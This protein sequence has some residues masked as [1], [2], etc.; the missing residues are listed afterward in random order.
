M[1]PTG[2]NSARERVLAVAERLFAERGYAAV[3]LRDI[4]AEVGLKHA[5][6]YH[7]VPGGKEALFIEVTERS[8]A[9]HRAGLERAI[10]QAGPDV[11]SQ[12]RGVADWLIS[13]PPMDLIRMSHADMP[14][15]E[16][17]QARRLSELTY[18]ALLLPVE[19]VLVEA[20]A[21][22]EIDHHNPGLIGGGLLGMLES[23][24]AIPDYAL[25]SP[26]QRHTFAYE[27]IDVVLNGL[28]PR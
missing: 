12:L 20:Q 14:A 1:E 26:N 10:T 4:A 22:G 7:H 8:M 23:L 6:L 5:S 17:G 21:R 11:R 27:M 9:H 13:H 3:T 15:I 16:P 18:E 24:H 25:E 28:R 19:R 2:D